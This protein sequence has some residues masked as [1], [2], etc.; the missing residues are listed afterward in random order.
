MSHHPQ[1]IVVETDELLQPSPTSVGD[2]KKNKKQKKANAA[3]VDC[4]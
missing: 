4:K 2:L 1:K 3:G